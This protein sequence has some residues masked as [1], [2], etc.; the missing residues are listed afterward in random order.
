MDI[1]LTKPCIFCNGPLKLTKNWIS[2][3]SFCAN[4]MIDNKTPAYKV[5]A[6]YTTPW[7]SRD[8]ISSSVIHI[9]IPKT[10]KYLSFRYNWANEIKETI[11]LFTIT[12]DLG[13]AFFLTD[14]DRIPWTFPIWSEIDLLPYAIETYNRLN[15]LK[16]FL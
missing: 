16:A 4:C 9:A 15:T 10:N 6:E 5:R 13:G 7:R 1:F 12:N 2:S 14:L 11:T 8:L 3:F